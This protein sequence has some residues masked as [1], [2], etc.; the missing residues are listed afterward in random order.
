M[1][2]GISLQ[3]SGPDLPMLFLAMKLTTFSL[4]VENT[5]NNPLY[6]TAKG[7]L[8]TLEAS[9]VVSLV[10]LQAMVLIAIFEYG[11]S[12]Y[13]AAW[14]TVGACVRFAELLG[15]SPGTDSMNVMSRV[16]CTEIS[17]YESM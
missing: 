12:I 17:D 8:A 1:Q 5:G 16:V 3:N 11:H 4:P 6:L 10:Y 13:P 15:L 7:F 14:M 9:G 2:I